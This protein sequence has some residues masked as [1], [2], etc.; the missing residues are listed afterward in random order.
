MVGQIQFTVSLIFI[1]LF[2]FAVV[3]FGIAFALDNEVSVD[4]SDDPDIVN[5]FA[6]TSG[7]LSKFRQASEDAY[8]SIINSTISPGDFTT[9]SGGQLKITP[10]SAMGV[11]KG[12]L[13]TGF[14][15]IF[16]N[17]SAFSVFITAFLSILVFIMG[18]L[19]WNAWFGRKAN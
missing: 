4:I 14:R 2:T 5:L 6:E 18:L 15:K 13:E 3:G 8:S 12:I 11:V 1:G 17:D 7:N 9:E 19:V 10:V 16:G